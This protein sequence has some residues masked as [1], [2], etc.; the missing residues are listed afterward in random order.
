ME[1][2]VRL[3]QIFKRIVISLALSHLGVVEASLRGQ[4]PRF[5]ETDD[6]SHFY[7]RATPKTPA[8]EER[9]LSS[10]IAPI[11]FY[12]LSYKGNCELSDSRIKAAS[13]FKS[14]R[15]LYILPFKGNLKKWSFVANKM[16]DFEP[17]FLSNRKSKICSVWE[18]ID[19]E[20]SLRNSVESDCL[21][22]SIDSSL[23]DSDLEEEYGDCLVDYLSDQ[24]IQ[25]YFLSGLSLGCFE[26]RGKIESDNNMKFNSSG[27]V[28][29]NQVVEEVAYFT[30]S[31]L[32]GAFSCSSELIQMAEISKSGRALISYANDQL[33]LVDSNNH[34]EKMIK[35]EKYKKF[36]KIR[37]I[38]FNSSASKALVVYGNFVVVVFGFKQSGDD[39]LVKELFVISL[40]RSLNLDKNYLEK[41][42]EDLSLDVDG[43]YCFIG[44]D[45]QKMANTT[46]TKIQDVFFAKDNKIIIAF[47]NKIFVCFLGKEKQIKMLP[48]NF[49]PREGILAI[50]Y[51]RKKDFM[52][53]AINNKIIVKDLWFN[54]IASYE[55]NYDF[56]SQLKFDNNGD[57]IAVVDGS[58]VA[59]LQLNFTGPC[60]TPLPR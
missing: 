13:F 6:F 22:Q 53:L 42:F 9:C 29:M 25:G 17:E 44:A 10:M 58:K 32:K 47:L 33:W 60:D 39:I 15:S 43:V 35:T 12:F 7:G 45:I 36:G 5:N 3:N 19:S 26:S 23:P 24:G 14:S 28:L 56:V 16:E 41:E 8:M 38:V 34:K 30:R 2:F 54:D 31:E 18:K 57:Q 4:E 40:E 55:G 46:S 27:D 37:K 20:L 52:V 50:D 59:I 51:N 48:C 11:S 21:R 49:N 1:L